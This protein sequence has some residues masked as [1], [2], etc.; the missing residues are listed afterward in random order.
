MASFYPPRK[1]EFWVLSL[2]MSA[3]MFSVNVSA[4]ESGLIKSFFGRKSVEPLP[5]DQAFQ[6]TARLIDSDKLSIQ[7]ILKPDYY[8]YKNRITLEL[9]GVPGMRLTRV[10]YP[11]AVTKQ[12]KSFGV[13]Q[14]YPKSFEIQGLITGTE[15]FSSPATLVARYQ[16][17]FETLGVCYP[18][19]VSEI[20]ISPR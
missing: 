14:V 19:Q 10:D 8:L 18:P 12:D 9:K 7:F 15:K 20:K 6:V 11:A 2:L 16:G 17:C 5:P 3:S 13:M 1:N 4:N